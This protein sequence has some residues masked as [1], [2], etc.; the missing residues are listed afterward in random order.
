MTRALLALLFLLLGPLPVAAEVRVDGFQRRVV[1]GWVLLTLQIRLP[2]YTACLLGSPGPLPDGDTAPVAV[3]QGTVAGIPALRADARSASSAVGAVLTAD[4]QTLDPGAGASPDADAAALVPHLL[5]LGGCEVD[6]LAMARPILILAGPAAPGTLMEVLLEWIPRLPP[7]DEVDPVVRRGARAGW[8][9]HVEPAGGAWTAVGL[10]VDVPPGPERLAVRVLWDLLD[11]ALAADGGIAQEIPHVGKWVLVR[12]YEGDPAQ[13]PARARA[14]HDALDALVAEG[15]DTPAM[16]RA[17]ARILRIPD[18]VPDDERWFADVFLAELSGGRPPLSGELRTAGFHLTPPFL[19][20]VAREVLP[21]G[22]V[23]VSSG[24]LG[25]EETGPSATERW[26]SLDPTLGDLTADARRV[27]G[28]DA[29]RRART[30]VLGER[31]ITRVEVRG[32]WE[33][34]AAAAPLA[35]AVVDRLDLPDR[36]ARRFEP[37]GSGLTFAVEHPPR[38][39][40]DLDGSGPAWEG[41]GARTARRRARQRLRIDPWNVLQAFDIASSGDPGKAGFAYLGGIIHDGVVF[42]GVRRVD[43]GDT[44]DVWLDPDDA[45]P[46]RLW[47]DDRQSLVPLEV[48]YLGVRDLGSGRYPTRIE[49]WRGPRREESIDVERVTGADV[50]NP[51]PLQ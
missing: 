31:T 5:T 4:P 20:R 34:A 1:D 49:W 18:E 11:V 30:R 8:W 7:V 46:A 17:R 32:R 26:P 28:R 51:D 41:D 19:A 48:R 27:L 47:V 29:I 9:R 23:L 35:G 38:A 14:V 37:D 36:I 33:L 25:E 2:E 22:S 44:L 42:Q 24:P 45:D 6:P 39:V 16:A 13:A 3:R 15:L 12:W 40:E 10:V 43:A 21:R 50:A